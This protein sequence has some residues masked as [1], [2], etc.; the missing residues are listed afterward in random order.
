[1]RKLLI[2]SLLGWIAIIGFIQPRNASAY[3]PPSGFCPS[4]GTYQQITYYNCSTGAWCGVTELRCGQD[5]PYH[6][7]CTTT[8]KSS[9]RA[10]CTCPFEP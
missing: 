7:G 2:A 6:S 4:G 10:S 1:M 9:L 3:P 8:C 5:E